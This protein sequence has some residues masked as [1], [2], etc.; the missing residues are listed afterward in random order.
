MCSPG[1]EPGALH[2][3]PRATKRPAVYCEGAT[4]RTRVFGSEHAD[5]CANRTLVF[6]G[7]CAQ[8]SDTNTPR[9][10]ARP[11]V[12]RLG[13][14]RRS[15]SVRVPAVPWYLCRSAAQDQAAPP[16]PHSST[17]VGTLGV[18]VDTLRDCEHP[19]TSGKS[20]LLVNPEHIPP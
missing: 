13:L 3:I 14:E 19:T 17:W 15:G 4:S 20:S 8:R 12:G 18:S 11:L 7:R 2:C 10:G 16:L 9:E 1:F 5:H 6:V